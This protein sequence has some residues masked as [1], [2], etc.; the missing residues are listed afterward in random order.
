[1]RFRLIVTLAGLLLIS[2]GATAMAG[3]HGDKGDGGASEFD[4]TRPPQLVPTE[5]RRRDRSES[6]TACDKIGGYQMS[7]I[8]DGLGAFAPDEGATRTTATTARWSC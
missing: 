6:L 4:T 1:M 8:P 2:T 7:G 3:G 5:S